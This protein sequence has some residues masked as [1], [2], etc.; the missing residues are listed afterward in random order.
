MN[1]AIS[2]RSGFTDDGLHI[3]AAEPWIKGKVGI[4]QQYLHTLV[5]TF[6]GKIDELVFVDLFAGSGI[7]SLGTRN[8]LFLSPPLQALSA[9]VPVT[10][11]ILCEKDADQVRTL[12]IRINKHFRGRN[13][14][15][16]EGRPETL[17]DKFDYFIPRSKG[18]FKVAVFCLCDSFAL[19]LNFETIKHLAQSGVNFLIPFSFP[20]ND[21]LSYKYY[22]KEGKDKLQSFLNGGEDLKQLGSTVESNLQFYKRLIRIYQANMLSLGYTLSIS[23]HKLD[24][25]LMELSSYQIGL[26]SKQVSV[27]AVQNKVE[28]T[29]H[30]QFDLFQWN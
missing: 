7:Y 22:L 18:T 10:K 5:E 14:L 30:V 1:H 27:R 8:D 6:E 3:T 23:T 24:S 16:L 15:L 4:I 17:H 29:R 11:F 2:P 9:N 25:G 12:K 13:V 19:D 21:R 28:A 26:F 20:L